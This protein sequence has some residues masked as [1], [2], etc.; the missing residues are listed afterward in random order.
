MDKSTELLGRHVDEATAHKFQKWQT[1]TI[2]G[3][4]VGYALFYIVRKNLSMAIPDMEADAT[5]NFTKADLGIFLT[6][7]GVVYGISKFANGFIGDRINARYFMMFGLSMC[8]IC[9]FVFGMSSLVWMFGLMW[10]LNGWFQGTG[11]PPCAR[12]LTH[13]VHPKQLATKM[14][15]WNTSHS[16]GAFVALVI[17]GYIVSLG[18][19]WCFY[20]PAIIAV[21]GVF[22]IWFV[23]RD[24]PTSV[25]LP[26]LSV[27]KQTDTVE[28]KKT[29]KEFKAIL[30]KRVF[31][32]PYIWILSIANFFVYTVRFAF[33]D[34]G[35]TMF[36]Q[37]LGVSKAQSGWLGGGFEL[38]GLGGMLLAG[39]ATDRYFKGRAARVCLI[40]MLLALAFVG[41][42]WMWRNND[43]PIIGSI[44]LLFGVGFFIYGPQALVGIAA[45]NLATKDAAASAVGL[46]GLFAYASTV[47]SGWGFGVVADKFGWNYVFFGLIIAAIIGSIV[48]AFVWRA[49]ADG[50]DD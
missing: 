14:S 25:G 43:M 50:Y 26:E 32:N 9:N 5:L 33:L 6:L 36:Q 39:W 13:W 27:G 44:I 31:C 12:L 11:Y 3:S 23:L 40:C 42:L 7:N 41:F 17:C 37:W 15:V 46:T 4:M 29:N 48:L 18:W 16:I 20:I 10:I 19:R 34:W 38:C 49:K 2:I 30:M 1:R 35:P 8:A 21:V 24:T 45:S 28:H 22:F 47:L